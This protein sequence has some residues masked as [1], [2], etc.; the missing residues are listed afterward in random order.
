M[1]KEKL[2]YKCT[3]LLCSAAL[4]VLTTSTN[5]TTLAKLIYTHVQ[6]GRVFITTIIYRELFPVSSL[7]KVFD[8]RVLFDGWKAARLLVVR[9]AL[10]E[11]IRMLGLRGSVDGVLSLSG[12][13]SEKAVWYRNTW[14]VQKCWEWNGIGQMYGTCMVH[15]WYM[16]GT[17]HKY[18]ECSAGLLHRHS[19]DGQAAVC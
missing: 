4:K 8:R 14:V 19:R 6:V 5:R 17:C 16:Y 18:L 11:G 3:Y 12:N 9:S 15:V 13:R 7:L 1:Y 2:V 10:K